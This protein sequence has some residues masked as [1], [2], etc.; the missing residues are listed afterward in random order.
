MSLS[1]VVSGG[2]AATPV[3]SVA[4][5]LDWTIS[6]WVDV[7]MTIL[8][9]CLCLRINCSTVYCRWYTVSLNNGW[10]EMQQ[11]ENC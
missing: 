2:L 7:K 9:V 5:T 10:I 1:F 4:V 3:G 11:P 8:Y 6:R